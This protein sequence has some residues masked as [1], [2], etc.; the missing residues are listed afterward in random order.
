MTTKQKAY[1]ALSATSI[2]WGTTWVAS[3]IGVQKAP[4]LEV[5]SIRQF[6]GGALYVLFFVFIKKQPLPTLK[7]MGW[8]T[9]MGILMF[10]S[11]NGIATLGLKYVSSGL[12]ALI[13]ALYPLCVVLIEYVFYRNRNITLLTFTGIILGIAGIGVVFYDDAFHN[14]SEG[15]IWGV[16]YS[17]IAMIT[18]SVATIFIARRKADINP[19]YATGWQMLTGSFILFL[20]V[21]ITGDHIPV[22]AIPA[23][24]WGALVYLVLAGSIFTFVAFI[25]SMKHLEPAIASLYA[26]VNP[27]VAILVGA[28]VVNEKLTVNILIGSLITL[29][30]VYLVNR[31][32]KK[33]GSEADAI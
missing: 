27:I 31:S 6:I 11:A 25:Y 15:Y 8:L 7:Q 30:G 32:M 16:L 3:K 13:A 28:L 4:A 9:F 18:W 21:M 14:R 26:Y 29:A 20:V 33:T 23:Q 24:T 12:G 10:V 22:S 5:A 2:I 17:L 19:Y 1:L